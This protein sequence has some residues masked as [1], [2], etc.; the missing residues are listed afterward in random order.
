[1]SV[2]RAIAGPFE[3]AAAAYKRQDYAETMRLLRPLADQGDATAQYNLG[4][5]YFNGQGVPQDYA[6]AMKWYRKSADQGHAGA[7]YNLGL[8]YFN[9][10]GVPQ[11]YAEAM[12][13]YRKSA[14][15]GVPLAQSNLGTLYFNGLGVPQDY[16]QALKWFILAASQLSGTDG[17]TAYKNCDLAA[18][19]M[20][21]AQFAEA[22]KLAREWKPTKP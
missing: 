19:K 12:K 20:T 22:V 13:L 6:E 7:Q 11:D 3:D 17:D 8:M 9:G 5:M 18:S 2:S 14:D 1:M 21:P 10:Q 16:V 4:L 15:Q